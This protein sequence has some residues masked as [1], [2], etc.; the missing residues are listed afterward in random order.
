[1]RCWRTGDKLKIYEILENRGQVE[2][3][4]DT[5]EKETS[6]RAMR[7]WRKGGKLKSYETAYRRTGT[8]TKLRVREEYII[9]L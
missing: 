2:E 5:G 6:S 3:L 9:N 1:M 4:C 8:V 7:Y